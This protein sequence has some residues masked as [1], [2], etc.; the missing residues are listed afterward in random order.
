LY[1][2][3]AVAGSS[4]GILKSY[5][6]LQAAIGDWDPATTL[7]V[8]DDDDTLTMMLCEKSPNCQYLGGPAWFTWQDGLRGTQSPHKITGD[9]G[10]LLKVSAFLFAANNMQY[11]ESVLP[12]VLDSLTSKGVR[13]LG[14]GPINLRDS[15]MR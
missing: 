8:L 4:K 9:F 2:S 13:L 5:N 12:S 6:D 1:S 10:E 7:L 11:T 15:R 3:L 14:S